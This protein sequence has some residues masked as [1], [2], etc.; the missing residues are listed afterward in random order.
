MDLYLF[1]SISEVQK[2]TDE[3]L[4]KYNNDRPHESLNNLTPVEF[5]TFHESLARYGSKSE[6]EN[7]LL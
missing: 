2:I 6:N 3:W 4:L 1:D 5:A 7:S